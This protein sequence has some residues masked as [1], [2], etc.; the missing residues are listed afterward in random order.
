M[1]LVWALP[2]LNSI[3]VGG[4]MED[5]LPIDNFN[6]LAQVGSILVE[7]EKGGDNHDFKGK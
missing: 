4:R 5:L 2:E 7:T 1:D 3:L 6:K